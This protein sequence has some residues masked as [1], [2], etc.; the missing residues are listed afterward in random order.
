MRSRA[1]V[2]VAY[3]GKVGRATVTPSLSAEW[4]HEFLD[5]EL[6]LDSRFGNGAGG[7]F[8]VRGPKTGRDSA[9]LT[10]AANV[11]W[12]RYSAYVA[13]QADLGRTNYESLTVLAG[14][15]VSW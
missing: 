8:S 3:T 1:G 7:V 12:S 13:Y 11:G 6:G 2:R 5:N 9:L 10:A 4:Q 15:R 14:F